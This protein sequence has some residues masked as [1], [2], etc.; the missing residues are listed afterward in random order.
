MINSSSTVID[1]LHEIINWIYMI[2]QFWNYHS[3]RQE[4]WTW[5]FS[6]VCWSNMKVQKSSKL[7]FD[8]L[9]DCWIR[10]NIIRWNKAFPLYFDH[11]N[12]QFNLDT[13]QSK[14]HLPRNNKTDSSVLESYHRPWHFYVTKIYLYASL[15]HIIH[16][17][18]SDFIAR[19]IGVHS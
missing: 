4:Q 10:K 8:P 9:L 2:H 16:A 6:W 15:T 19:L 13:L 3:L 17:I 7:L 12:S 11:P 14:C 1:T 5:S 18:I